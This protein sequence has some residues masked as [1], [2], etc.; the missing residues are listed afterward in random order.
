MS[1]EQQFLHLFAAGFERAQ[2]GE[3]RGANELY[4]RA[5]KALGTL[6]HPQLTAILANLAQNALELGDADQG[7]DYFDRA[8]T[9]ALDGGPHPVAANTW[10]Q[11]AWILYARGETSHAEQALELVD[12]ALVSDD[13]LETHDTRMR[14]LLKLGREAEARRIA[15]AALHRE[16]THR[17]FQDVKARWGLTSKRA[18]AAARRELATPRPVRATPEAREP[19]PKRI[20]ELG[21]WKG[22]RV[23]PVTPRRVEKKEPKLELGGLGTG[24]APRASA[25]G[26][27][28]AGRA[29]R[30]RAQEILRRHLR[31]SPLL[32]GERPPRLLGE[33][34]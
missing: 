20:D 15:V 10:H 28:G 14:I 9:R 12:R 26:G 7:W 11:F 6:D 4:E 16:F 30:A 5:L 18:V 32:A 24:R 27:P 17:D 31:S 29:P 13:R 8:L 23:V 21:D 2:R 22:R 3:L 34:G 25:T 33:L 19:R 1:A